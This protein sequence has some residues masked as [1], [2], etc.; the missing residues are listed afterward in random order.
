MRHA[1]ILGDGPLS[2]YHVLSRVIERRFILGE[3]EQEHFKKLM[4]AQEAFAGVRVLT[5]NCMSNHFHMLV[6]VESREA[7]AVQRQLAR[8]LEDDVVFL[9]RL[10]HVYAPDV[11]EDIGK[12][13]ERLR[14]GDGAGDLGLML[15]KMRMRITLPPPTLGRWH[16]SI[17]PRRMRPRCWSGGSSGWRSSNSRIWSGCMTC[18]HLWA[19]SSSG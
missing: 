11:V 10:R 2:Y 12:H 3:Q 15:M 1:R 18:R 8:L 9:E 5:W 14:G 6:A 7:E 13:L 4:R 19:S 16:A 17:L